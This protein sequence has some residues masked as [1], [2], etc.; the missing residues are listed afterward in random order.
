MNLTTFSANKAHK[1]VLFFIPS[2]SFFTANLFIITYDYYYFILFY[3][4]FVF[5]N[6]SNYC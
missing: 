2:I 4:E 1:V 3:F 6:K 5:D